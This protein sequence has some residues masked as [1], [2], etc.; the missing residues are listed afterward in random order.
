MKIRIKRLRLILNTVLLLLAFFTFFYSME[1]FAD[2]GCDG[3]T[4]AVLI[5]MYSLP[6]MLC[7]AFT[8]LAFNKGLSGK[9]A[10]AAFL[11]VAIILN[12]F[13]IIPDYG[14]RLDELNLAPILLFAIHGL[15]VIIF[16]ISYNIRK[17]AKRE[18]PEDPEL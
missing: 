8:G 17:K 14:Y 2:N 9:W 11:V 3:G 13:L 5:I 7:W 16:I 4:C 12:L 10:F 18:K 15:I 6:L 1:H